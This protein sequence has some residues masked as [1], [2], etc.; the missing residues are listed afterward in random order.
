M[1]KVFLKI[2]FPIALI[3]G[4]V[5]VSTPNTF[6]KTEH[7]KKDKKGCNCCRPIAGKNKCCAEH[8]DS[9]QCCEK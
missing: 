5:L 4:G 6:G 7:T 2:A 9:L 1:S 3:A 8:G